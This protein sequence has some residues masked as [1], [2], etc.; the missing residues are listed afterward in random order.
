M[1][2]AL[3]AEMTKELQAIKNA[4]VELRQMKG[5]KKNQ[6]LKNLA[7]LLVSNSKEILDA[8]VLDLKS[9]TNQVSAYVD[10]LTLSLDRIKA[11][12]ESLKA[13]AD[14]N[15]P[16]GEIVEEKTLKNGLKLK[17]VR[18]PLGVIFMIF[19]SR[20]N[21]ATE[22]FSMAFK[23][24]NAIILRGGRES[25]K[26]V[27]VIYSL[28][29]KSLRES[30]VD[31]KSFLGM[32][33]YDRK[34]VDQLLK[35]KNYI[36]I[37]VPRGGEQLISHVQSES[38]M[39]VIKN[40]RGLC[41]TYV[42]EDA[43]LAMASKIVSNAKASR[44]SVC[45]SLETVLIHKKVAQVFLPMLSQEMKS[46]NMQYF[47]CENSMKILKDQ[48]IS[49]ATDENFNTEYLDYK[50]NLKVVED[51]GEALEHI[52]KFG[53]RHSEAIISKSET[54][55]RHFQNQ[56]DAAVVYWN[57]STRFT[58]GFEMALGGEIGIS[59]QKL[60]VRGPVGL[61]E[62]TTA[63]WIADGNGQIR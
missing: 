52:E 34:L 60:H 61:R 27:A 18:A 47:G 6:V 28:I 42:H 37:V 50:M 59:T 7:S 24:G 49:L 62:L 45:N 32:T 14:L 1:S 13:V 51:L 41:H 53:S 26:T 48:K 36:D 57:A 16:V 3:S 4:W 56:V 31:E 30:G 55:A 40:D 43:D 25:E 12:A 9:N 8:N 11:M 39:P 22:A 35:Q 5:E 19:E 21:V 2:D 10:R 23:S 63:R 54:T 46:Y 38:L 17:R 29:K 20:P 15:D 58:D 33:N 44:P